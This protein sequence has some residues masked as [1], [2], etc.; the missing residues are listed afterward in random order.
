MDRK[1]GTTLTHEAQLRARGKNTGTHEK[2]II[3]SARKDR[4][5]AVTVG[6]PQVPR[7]LGR[8]KFYGEL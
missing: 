3:P 5:V 7:R 2:R 8:L 6:I 1:I 4:I